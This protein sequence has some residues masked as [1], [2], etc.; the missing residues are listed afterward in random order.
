MAPA[1]VGENGHH[2]HAAAVAPDDDGVS[3][4]SSADFEDD[5]FHFHHEPKTCASK[6]TVM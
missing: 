2:F 5:T 3:S 1:P 4:V 6:C